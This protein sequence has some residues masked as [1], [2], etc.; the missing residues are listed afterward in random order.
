MLIFTEKDVQ[1][2]LGD[3]I[4]YVAKE[5]H[6]SDWEWDYHAELLKKIQAQN[7]PVYSALDSFFTAY[8]EWHQFHATT[9]AEGKSGNLSQEEHQKLMKLIERR[10]S[11]REA[12][13]STIRG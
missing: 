1:V 8:K 12:L 7:T 11:S 4:R 6:I 10:D 2:Y 3:I 5:L 13:I 9:D